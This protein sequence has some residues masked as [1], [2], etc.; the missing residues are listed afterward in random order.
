MNEK[1]REEQAAEARM[2]EMLSAALAEELGDMPKVSITV[3]ELEALERADR[4]QRRKRRL[5]YFSM[6]A[7]VFFICVVAL[8]ALWPETA[9]PVSADK[10]T[11]QR[12]EEKDGMVVINE[13]DVE[14]SGT[15]SYT[16]DDESKILELKKRFK[17]LVT[18]TYLPEGYLFSNLTIEDYAEEGFL[19]QYTFVKNKKNIYV[20]QQFYSTSGTKTDIANNNVDFIETKFGRAYIAKDGKKIIA[21]VDLDNGYLKV[22]GRLTTKEIVKIIDNIKEGVT[23]SS[24]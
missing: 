11:E 10:N 18:L 2:A 15:I 19:A 13:G 5:R 9:V 3:E 23:K 24:N 1:N 8:Y 4:Q 20:A 16:E 22:T 6:A 7:A 17:D 21:S 14:G 12:V